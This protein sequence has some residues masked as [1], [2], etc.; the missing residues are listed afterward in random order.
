MRI[1]SGGISQETNTFAS[2]PT[3]LDDF[4]RDSGGDPAFST[5]GV[6]ALYSGTATIHGGYVDAARERGVDL[7]PTLLANA[8]PGGTIEESAYRQLKAMLLERM[9]AVLP[10][11]GVLLDLHGAMVTAE[12][13]DAEGDVISAVRDLVGRTVPVVATL[14][15]HANITALMAEQA[16]VLI[17]YDT[18]PHVDMGDRGVEALNLIADIAAGQVRP[19][20]AYQQLPLITMPPLQ[21]TLR[22]PMSRLLERMHA[23]ESEPGVMTATLSMGFPFADIQDAGVS[24]LVTADGD[25]ALAEAKAQALADEVWEEREA[26]NVGLTPVRE[27]LRY[28]REEATGLVVLADGSDNPGGGGPSDGTVIL[29]ALLDEGTEAAVVGVLCDPETVAQAHEAGV[30]TTIDAV[31]GGK[32]DR[33]HGDPVRTQAYVRTLG[34]GEFVYRGPMGRGARGHLGRTAVLVIGGTEVVVSERRDQLRDAEMLRT[35]GIEPRDRRLL[36]V[37]SAVHFRT[38]IGTLAERIFDADTPGVHRPDFSSYTYEQ[39]R[40]PIYP[41]DDM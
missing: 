12:H 19:S 36:A 4:V 7:V 24:V 22:Q 5:D 17:G 15:L 28:V 41:L 14:D 33:L 9:E 38:D 26:F 29:Q 6:E 10:V 31:I 35:V 21:C 25:L 8:T 18:Y 16:D 39:V 13:Q 27:V 34:D 23:I 1:A 3:T 32:T 37:K 30:G 40:R 11:D 2:H 20:M